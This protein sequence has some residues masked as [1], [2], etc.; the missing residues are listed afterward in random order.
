MSA[1]CDFSIFVRIKRFALANVL[2]EGCLDSL[3]IKISE[4]N[5]KG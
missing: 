3:E 1:Q 4:S 2:I 5:Q